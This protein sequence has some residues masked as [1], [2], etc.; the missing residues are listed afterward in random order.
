MGSGTASAA[1]DAKAL[2]SEFNPWSVP[3]IVSRFGTRERLGSLTPALACVAPGAAPPRIQQS[4][5]LCI[6][7]KKSQDPAPLRRV[8]GVIAADE[9]VVGHAAVCQANGSPRLDP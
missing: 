5:T 1:G 9:F 8:H 3:R 7:V 2:R 6:E 4:L